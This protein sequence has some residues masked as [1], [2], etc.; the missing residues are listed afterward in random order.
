[1]KQ[2]STY[3]IGGGLVVLLLL[4][5]A[6]TN[7]GCQR[8]FSW[9][10]TYDQNSKEPYG[11][12]IFYELLKDRYSADNFMVSDDTL[13]NKLPLEDALTDE[14]MAY[15]FV[16]AAMYLDSNS[17]ESLFNFAAGGNDVFISSKT[18]PYYLMEYLYAADC[19]ETYWNDYRQLNDSTAQVN[20]TDSELQADSN[21]TLQYYKRFSPS[22]YNWS[23]IDD[24]V[25]CAESS[26]ENL[27]VMN[28]YLPIFARVPYDKGNIYL[29][30]TPLAFSN[31]SLKK[32]ENLEY[33]EKVLSYTDAEKVFYDAHSR[34]SE[35]VG[36]R[37]NQEF[38][39]FNN[40]TFNK[41][42]ELSYILSQPALR[43]AWYLTLATALLYLIFR[44]KR[45][46]RI[47]PVTEENRNTSLEFI[48]T[49]GQLYFQQ[50]N[51]RGL[52]LQ[53]MKLWLGHV[54]EK[55]RIPAKD[56]DAEFVKKLAVK[57]E[58]QADIIEDVI[59][60][61]QT[62]QGATGIQEHTLIEFH[63]AVERFYDLSK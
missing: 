24:R 3:L 41:D 62:I 13:A 38:D 36:R 53:K 19:E 30:T 31:F 10:E 18:I 25:F 37:Q 33:V 12:Y 35:G 16:G 5:F 50:N 17:V 40:R 59:S 28:D 60:K 7:R 20:F 63:Q 29:H 39:L 4:F 1:M 47:I 44:A 52:A 26:F 55:Y 51:H 58:V 8:N 9:R 49:I 21:F 32:E 46:Q 56:L 61:Y 57:A 2:Q 43:W 54:R 42:N 6:L 23:Y 45:E 15:I 27:G 34:I 11:A 14:K 48:G 22:S